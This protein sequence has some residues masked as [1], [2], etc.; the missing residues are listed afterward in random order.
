[1]S[2]R[3]LTI[4]PGI[5]ASLL[6][7]PTPGT[8]A[9]IREL[10]LFALP[11]EHVTTNL[12]HHPT[13][14]DANADAGGKANADNAADLPDSGAGVGVLLCANADVNAGRH[15]TDKLQHVYR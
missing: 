2:R 1:M 15:P 5:A 11:R 10:Y 4:G 8:F 14:A 13:G 9:R 7:L 3:L 12:Y 6:P